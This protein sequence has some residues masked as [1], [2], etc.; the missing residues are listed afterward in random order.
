MIFFFGLV[1]LLVYGDP[2]MSFD[3]ETSEQLSK[4]K[5]QGEVEFEAGNCDAAFAKYLKCLQ[6]FGM[7]LPTSRFDSFT[8]T[9]W[10]FIRMCLHRIWIGR[11]LSR[12]TGGLFCA[13][14]VR[15]RAL[16]SAKEL[17]LIMHRLNQLHLSSKIADSHGFMMSL[18]AINMGEAAADIISPEDMIE[19]YLTAALRVK[20]TYPKFLQFFSR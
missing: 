17:S 20:R 16:Q 10:Q 19:I 1:K 9:T 14:I 7:D 18:F 13:D 3:T 8:L 11:W 4:Y 12:K 2:I 5:K 6:V 15:K